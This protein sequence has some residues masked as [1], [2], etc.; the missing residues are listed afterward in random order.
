MIAIPLI[1]YINPDMTVFSGHGEIFLK[2]DWK[3]KNE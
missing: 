2:Q 3:G 1:N